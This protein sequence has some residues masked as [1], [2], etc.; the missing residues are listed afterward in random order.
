MCVLFF[1]RHRLHTLESSLQRQRKRSPESAGGSLEA[2]EKT[3][4][5]QQC[6]RNEQHQLQQRC[7]GSNN[8]HGEYVDLQ[9]KQ[10]Q[11]Q[12]GQLENLSRKKCKFHILTTIVAKGRMEQR[13]P[14]SSIVGDRCY[15]SEE[16]CDTADLDLTT[17]LKMRNL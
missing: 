2:G 15:Y 12:R 3:R 10:Y 5:R 9:R 14:S 8:S 13:F 1:Y 11:L 6:W 4:H 17:G 16:Y 7:D